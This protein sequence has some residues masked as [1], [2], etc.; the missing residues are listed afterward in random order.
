[1]SF[2]SNVSDL[3]TRVATEIKSVRT[4]VN[5]N[6]A[7]LSA[8][9]TT[10]KANLVAAINELNTAVQNAAQTGGASINDGAA[11]DST[12]YS[13]SK[14]EALV[15]AATAALV[16][17]SPAAL[18]TLDEL[19]NALGDDP[20][21]ATTILSG[22]GNRVRVDAAQTLTAPQQAQARS[23]IGAAGTADVGDPNTDFVATF[24]SGL[25]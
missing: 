1:M 6:A 10:A 8:L 13:A 15:S 25:A 16:D 24:V 7:D 14:I 5:G 18:N 4:L 19:A 9:N 2:S 3:A 11:S 20:N 17:N 22:L 21:F 12:T 23:N